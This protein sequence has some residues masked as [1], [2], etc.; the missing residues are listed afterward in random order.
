MPAAKEYKPS[1]SLRDEA[2]LGVGKKRHE[3]GEMGGATGG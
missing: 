1:S 3:G 2:W